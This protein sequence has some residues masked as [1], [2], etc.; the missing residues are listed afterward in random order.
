MYVLTNLHVT[1]LQCILE[2]L[3]NNCH[4]VKLRS[5]Q[6]RGFRV[7]REYITVGI[8]SSRYICQNNRNAAST[9]LI[10]ALMLL[11]DCTNVLTL[12]MVNVELYPLFFRFH[13]CR[14]D[15]RQGIWY[16]Y[17]VCDIIQL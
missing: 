3:C 14:G 16:Y 10:T 11:S 9:A 7:Q 15:V 6:A 17:R 2:Y 13:V 8:C 4:S 5:D 1:W 12:F